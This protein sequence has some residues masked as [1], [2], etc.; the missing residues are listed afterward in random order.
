MQAARRAA[1]AR[2]PGA[3]GWSVRLCSGRAP[4]LP[5]PH[6]VSCSLDLETSERIVTRLE[7]RGRDAI[8]RSL[9]LDYFGDLQGCAHVVELGAGTGVVSRALCQHEGFSGRVTGVDQSEHFV[10]AAERLARAEGSWDPARLSFRV[11][12]ASCA[13]DVAT[14]PDAVVANTLLSHVDDIGRV[15]AAARAMV[16]PGARLVAMDGDYDSLTFAHL[17]DPALGRRMDSALTA[18]VFAQ[19]DA[20]RRL[21]GLLAEAGWRLEAARGQCVS[22]IGG[23]AS[24]WRSFAEAYMPRVV[25]AGLLSQSEVDRWWSA[26]M[27]ALR[28]GR[29]FAAANYY[30]MVARAV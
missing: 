22:E 1:L 5:D 7:S 3:V 6:N 16:A 10:R 17:E 24:Y 28:A 2:A 21:P 27:E 15:L 18:A 20:M 23:E 11:G 26:Q 12:D 13:V 30:T 14:A 19:P 25:Q 29:F 4:L 9:F 8:F